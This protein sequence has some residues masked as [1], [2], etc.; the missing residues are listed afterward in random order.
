[1]GIAYSPKI[2]TD[3]LVLCLDAANPRSYPGTGTTWTYL[4]GN[5]NNGTLVNGVGYTSDN[6]GSLVFDGVNDYINMGASNTWAIGTDGTIEQWV[7]PTDSK[8]NDRLWS[9]INNSSSLDAYLNGTGYNVY[10]HGAT[11]GTTTPL[12]KDAWNH[13]VASY[14]G[15]TVQLYIN[16]IAGVMTGS[17]VFNITNTGTLYIGRFIS[18][19]YEIS[20]SISGTKLYNRGL[21]A[22]EVQQNFNATRGRYG[23]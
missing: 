2:V 4:S 16:G 8:G 10:M 21:S 17:P 19:G 18:A 5:G 6:K 7:Y 1:M 14:I 3:G 22:E 12:I 20:G 11:V 23:I 15:G 13:L 9:V